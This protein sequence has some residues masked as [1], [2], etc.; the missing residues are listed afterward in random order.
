MQEYEELRNFATLHKEVIDYAVKLV[1]RVRNM[2]M[3]A[4]ALI[5]ADRS[6]YGNIPMA[7]SSSK[8]YWVSMWTEGRNAQLSK[9]GYN[10]W[11]I[12]GLK[13]LKYIL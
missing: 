5:I 6:L 7:K 11:D 3:H 12:L 4:G 2:G 13:T 1:G 8:G 10:K 9:F